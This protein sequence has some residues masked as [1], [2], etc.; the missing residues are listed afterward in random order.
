MHTKQ[1]TKKL[2]ENCTLMNENC[3]DTQKRNQKS[4]VRNEH[5]AI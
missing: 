3:Y 4:H 1:K 2:I 5:C